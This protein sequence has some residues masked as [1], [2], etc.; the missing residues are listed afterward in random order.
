MKNEDIEICKCCGLENDNG[1]K[2]CFYC[3]FRGKVGTARFILF[4]SMKENDNKPVTLDE[5]WTLD[6]KMRK[7]LGKHTVS[8]SAVENILHRYS[9]HY[10]DCKE[11]KSG[12][13]LLKGKKYKKIGK[14]KVSGRPENTYRL[15]KHLSD[16]LIENEESW[17]LGYPVYN[18]EGREG[19]K[20]KMTEEYTL[21][22]KKIAQKIR[23]NEYELYEYLLPDYT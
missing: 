12:Y 20:F 6:C 19:V 8:K 5:A 7:K 23:D 11:R 14:K 18:R 21:K 16:R 13:L 9:K 1:Y 15:S 3:F 22:A 4:K 10:E 2:F 17:R